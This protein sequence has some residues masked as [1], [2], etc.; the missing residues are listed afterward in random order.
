MQTPDRLVKRMQLPLSAVKRISVLET[1]EGP[2]GEE[3]APDPET[4]DDAELY[5]ALLR[6]F[7]DSSL[8][9]GAT[10]SALQSRT[11]KRKQVIVVALRGK[12]DFITRARRWIARPARDAKCGTMCMKSLSTLRRRCHCQTLALLRNWQPP[13]LVGEQQLFDDVNI[14]FSLELIVQSA[15]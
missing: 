4:F 10:M 11:K 14:I 6:E 12:D 9:D 3:D 5:G 13:C 1:A 7:L 8:V 15:T 2:L